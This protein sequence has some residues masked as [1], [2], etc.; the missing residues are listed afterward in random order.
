MGWSQNLVNLQLNL[1]MNTSAA[2]LGKYQELRQF[3]QRLSESNLASVSAYREMDA[4]NKKP[5]SPNFDTEEESEELS[6]QGEAKDV[7]L[8]ICLYSADKFNSLRYDFEMLGSQEIK[9][10]ISTLGCHTTMTKVL[11][12]LGSRDFACPETLG[13]FKRLFDPSEQAVEHGATDIIMHLGQRFYA[14]NANNRLARNYPVLPL[15]G[16]C[17][18]DKSVQIRLFE[19][20]A[21]C[22]D[23]FCQHFLIIKQLRLASQ[24]DLD[25]LQNVQ[26]KLVSKLKDRRKLCRICDQFSATLI[27]VDDRLAPD[28]P[29]SF[30]QTCF[31]AL[32]FDQK[33]AL[34]FSDFKLY[35]STSFV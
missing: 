17:W 11:G 7:V 15:E 29:C 13:E 31:E 25:R 18:L 4:R 19:P 22:H 2:G 35:P 28:N 20:Y 12:G 16:L 24:Q 23:G 9:A 8:Q 32:H 26:M 30:C 21:L 3:S 34:I 1:N 6:S 33:G 5:K 27:T 14:E 10:A